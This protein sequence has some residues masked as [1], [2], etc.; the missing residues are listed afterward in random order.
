MKKRTPLLLFLLALFVSCNNDSGELTE[1]VGG[2]DDGSS[3]LNLP[4]T[5]FNYANPDFPASFNNF[6][7]TVLDNTPANNP[8][9]NAGATL[10]RVLFY[11]KSLSANNTVSCASCH[12]QSEGFSDSRTFS[13]GFEGGLTGRNSM[14]LANARFGENGK[15]FWD[16]RAETLEE[17]VLMPIQDPVEMGMDLNDLVT[18][19]STLT[20]YPD[21]FT[22]AFGSPEIT[23]DR[24]SRA[25]AQFVRAMVSYETKYDEG[26]AQTGNFFAPFPNFTAQENL[27]KSIFNGS[28]TP[29]VVDGNCALCH[30]NNDGV[31]ISPGSNLQNFALFTMVSSPRNNGIDLDGN[32]DDLGI[33]GAIPGATTAVGAFKSPSLRN[34]ELTAPYMHDGRLATLEDVVEHYSTGVLPHPNL[35]FPALADENGN[36][37]HLNLT[38][39]QKDA[40]VA[41]LKTLTDHNFI[42]DEKFSD[43]FN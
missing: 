4:A 7:M 24:I 9:T 13:E 6:V 19:L 5:H 31:A 41:F 16:H 25:L 20:Y 11:D 8:V 43:P 15:F 2:G 28:F 37:K 21:L 30:M 38:Q 34:I 36:A 40:L 27:G 22:D 12:V 26:L 32:V 33:G 18:K 1:I 39:E 23:S 29:G 35:S 3:I 10:G 42:N 14:G 17:Q